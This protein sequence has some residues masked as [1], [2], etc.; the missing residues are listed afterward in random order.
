VRG[1]LQ[2]AG[3]KVLERAR[4]N[5]FHYP[6]PNAGYADLGRGAGGGPLCN[7]GRGTEVHFDGDTEAVT[8]TFA[9][10]VALELATGKVDTAD[11]LALRRFELALAFVQWHTGL[12]RTYMAEHG[13]Y[14]GQPV[15][16]PKASRQSS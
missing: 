1:T 11:E 10:D 8:L 2:R 9:D 6:A 7:E 14:S 5:T 4:N 12:I 15:S 13:H 16:K 3:K